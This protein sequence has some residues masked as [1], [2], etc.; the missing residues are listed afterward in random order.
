LLTITATRYFWLKCVGTFGSPDTYV[1]TVE[2]N[3][4]GTVPA[5]ESISATGFTSYLY[6]GD[7]TVAGGAITA[8]PNQ[9]LFSSLYCESYG[10]VNLWSAT[11]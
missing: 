1:V 3:G 6:I 8:P 4:T 11:S 9:Y 5:A 7:I 2:S 10:N